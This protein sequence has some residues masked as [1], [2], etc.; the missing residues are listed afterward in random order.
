MKM[1][2][3]AILLMVALSAIHSIPV[4]CQGTIP[5]T[6]DEL[7]LNSPP[8]A[9]FG[10]ETSTQLWQVNGG[11]GL[12]GK[13]VLLDASFKLGLNQTSFISLGYGGAL[14][15]SKN[16][17][18]DYNGGPVSLFTWGSENVE[19]SSTF[20]LTFGAQAFISNSM[21]WSFEAGPSL[22]ACTLIKYTRSYDPGIGPNYKT[23]EIRYK[24]V[25]GLTVKTVTNWVISDAFG[26]DIGLVVNLNKRFSYGALKLGLNI[27]QLR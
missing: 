12:I 20:H 19:S 15:R 24:T 14:R 22:G 1:P 23:D 10:S 5:A 26:I 9:S 13:G 8:S 16:K 7:T 4:Q 21:V 25:P 17:P 27:G 2:L 3:F 11:L 18:H 6:I